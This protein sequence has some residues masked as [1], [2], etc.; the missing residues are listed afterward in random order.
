VVVLASSKPTRHEVYGSASSAH[1][2]VRWFFFSYWR[3]NT[4]D[5]AQDKLLAPT[6]FLLR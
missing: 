3:V 4:P 1:S 2:C 6:A 5:N